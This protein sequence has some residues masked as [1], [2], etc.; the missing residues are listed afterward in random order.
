MAQS[1]CGL[2][3]REGGQ[4]IVRKDKFRVVRVDDAAFPAFYRVI[5]NT[6]V[7]ELSDLATSDRQA[8]MEAVVTVERVL[9]AQLR[10]TK[11]NLA[12]L[13]NMV[14]H[15]HWHVIARFEWD[16]QFPHPVW[17]VAQ[18]AVDPSPR[19]RLPVTLDGLDLA[20]RKAFD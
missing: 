2:C 10:P 3:V 9:R 12:S 14:P 18:R 8:C 1:S 6:H 4:P 17:G 7:C 16:S 19:S 13:G 20:I 11:I 15:L 5:W